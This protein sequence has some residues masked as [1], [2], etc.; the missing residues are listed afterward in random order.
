MNKTEIIEALETLK[1]EGDIE[2]G[3]CDADKILCDLLTRLGYADVVE[4][5]KQIPKWYA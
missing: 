4:A 3:H 5:Y 1:N 2:I